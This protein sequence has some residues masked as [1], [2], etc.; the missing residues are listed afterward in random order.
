VSIP[1]KYVWRNI[2]PG[3][4][5]ATKNEKGEVYKMKKHTIIILLVIV[6]L[7]LMTKG[8]AQEKKSQGR[9]STE[10][11]RI[12]AFMVD[13]IIGSE[14]MNLKGETLGKIEDIVIDIDTGRVLYA[15]MDFGSFLGIGGKLFPVPWKSLAALPSEGIFF[16]N[17]SKKQLEKAPGFDKNNL[18]DM[19]DVHWGEEITQ[20][21][22][23]SREEREDFRYDHGYG[24]DLYPGLAQQDPFANIFDPK[25]IKKI[26]GQ[27]IKV[28]QVIPK[29]GI[30]SQMEIE[31]IVYVGRKDAVPVYLGPEWYI[32]GPNRRTP[33]KSGDEVTVTGSWITS[34]GPPFMIASSITQGKETLRLRDKDGTAAWIGWKKTSD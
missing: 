7:F 25:S 6:G 32:G 21:Y 19:G 17:R 14:V 26:S 3:E 1:H 10:S 34:E 9:E 5:K 28:D 16:L 29:S 18:P 23:A 33:F 2:S 15:V 20:F 11:Q 13:K 27:V 4:A 8:F 30:I 12:N 24:Y 31:L 22:Q